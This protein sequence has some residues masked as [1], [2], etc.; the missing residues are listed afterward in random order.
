MRDLSLEASD[1]RHSTHD[2]LEFALG[3]GLF[4]ARI[5]RVCSHDVLVL[6]CGRRI[7]MELHH[8]DVVLGGSESLHYVPL[9]IRKNYLGESLMRIYMSVSDT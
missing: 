3:V 9:C 2:S 1:R 4:F 7:L 8:R 6:R 5:N